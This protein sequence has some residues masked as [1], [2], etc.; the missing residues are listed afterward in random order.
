M[1][2]FHENFPM[3]LGLQYPVSLEDEQKHYNYKTHKI[4]LVRRQLQPLEIGNIIKLHFASNNQLY[5]ARILDIRP[6]QDKA[7]HEFDFE[8]I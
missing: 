8:L 1:S 2:E 7:N 5:R 3:E 4:T 6:T